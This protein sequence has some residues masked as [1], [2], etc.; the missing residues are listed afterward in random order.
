MSADHGVQARLCAA[1][2]PFD[3]RAGGAYVI[4]G[5]LRKRPS[6]S[7]PFLTEE[8]LQGIAEGLLARAEKA[9][10][11]A[12]DVMAATG[13][14]LGVSARAGALEEVE[15]S[16]SIDFGLRVMLRSE[17]GV[18]VATI[19]ASD[20]SERA[21]E[22]L[23][24]RAVAM[25]KEAPVDAYAGLAPEDLLDRSDLAA[26]IGE[27][28]LGDPAGPPDPDLLLSEALELEQV[29]SS[30]DGVSQVEG[31][32]SSWSGGW[33]YLATSH[34]FKGGYRA[35]SRSLSVGAV[36]GSGL[37]MERDY[38]ASAARFAEDLRPI[39][40]IGLEAGRR[41]IR[42]L[43]PKK[44][45][46]GAYPVLFEPRMASGLVSAVIGAA[47]GAGVARGSSFLRDKMGERI[48]PERFTIMDD[49]SRKRGLASRP[50]DGEGVAA[51]PKAIVQDGVLSAWLLD[52][53]SAKRL[54][55]TSNGSA[56]RGVA[57]GPSPSSSNVWITPGEKTP[58]ELIRDTGRGVLI[59]EMMGRGVNGV[60]GDYSRGASGFWI[61]DGEVAYPIS[62]FTVAG[63]I[64]EMLSG[65]EAAN[66]LV[67][68]RRTVAPTLRVEGLT[69]GSA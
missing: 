15:R 33:A 20:P 23:V 38:A 18:R 7:E 59:A 28:E 64:F 68:D 49:P 58:E 47:N 5:K 63:H 66:D 65:L 35:S 3:L 37:S 14:A 24:E 46:S 45:P 1:R 60:T 11:D 26:R 56:S 22:A 42:R 51:R 32:D 13:E 50:F 21:L 36:A 30:V 29:A 16:E 69:I 52:C 67:F 39:E 44:P 27:L 57:G 53:E 6:L 4:F 55:L 34:G 10:A 43:H 12:A 54:G 40:E 8:A 61:E 2:R 62:E 31:A 9:G 19:S 17:D 48:L 25:A 41:A